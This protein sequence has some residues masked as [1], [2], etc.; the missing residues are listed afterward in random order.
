MLLSRPKLAAEGIAVEAT[1]VCREQH[2]PILCI[3]CNRG[4]TARRIQ[5]GERICQLVFVPVPSINWVSI[6]QSS[7]TE[8][9]QDDP[10]GS[11][12]Q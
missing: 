2:E 4:T 12:H 9:P 10:E 8:H 3:L 6:Q 5:S 7:E 11:D 1:M